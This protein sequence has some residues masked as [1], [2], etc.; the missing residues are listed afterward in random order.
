MDVEDV[1]VPLPTQICPGLY[2]GTERHACQRQLLLETL[3]YLQSGSSQP[4]P[5]RSIIN[6]TACSPNVFEESAGVTASTAESPD[7]EDEAALRFAYWRVAP[8]TLGAAGELTPA[9]RPAL[10]GATTFLKDA[11]QRKRPVLVH[12]DEGEGGSEAAATIVAAFLAEARA[13]HPAKAAEAVR[14]RRPAAQLSAAG[15]SRLEGLLGVEASTAAPEADGSLEGLS[16]PAAS[17]VVEGFLWL[18]NADAATPAGLRLLGVNAVLNVS[19]SLPMPDVPDVACHRMPASLSTGWPAARDFLRAAR[20]ENKR[21]LVFCETSARAAVVIMG[22]LMDAERT[23]TFTMAMRRV[24]GVRS[25]LKPDAAFSRQLME[26]KLDAEAKRPGVDHLDLA[27]QGGSLPEAPKLALEDDH[28]YME[29]LEQGVAQLG[30]FL[31]GVPA[32]MRREVLVRYRGNV[33]RAASEL[34]GWLEGDEVGGQ[35]GGGGAASSAGSSAGAVASSN[36][37]G[38]AGSGVAAPSAGDL[39]G[40]WRQAVGKQEG[41][42]SSSSAGVATSGSPGNPPN[43]AASLPCPEA[44]KLVDQFLGGEQQGTGAGSSSSSAAVVLQ[45][46]EQGLPPCILCDGT[47]SGPRQEHPGLGSVHKS[48][49]V[50]A[51]GMCD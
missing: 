29:R 45:H 9:S 22:H 2:L 24:R 44:V 8:S 37:A 15:V 47:R 39:F 11:L 49:L 50:E 35:R 21:V 46:E 27:V 1:T 4:A 12:G 43:L 5:I 31:P 51:T 14:D 30:D 25:G 16:P 36:S 32:D 20:H 18:G 10:K 41:G 23:L 28:A 7:D 48:C 34:M 17:E 42:A 13:L 26:V 19:Q 38:S 3:P 6:A 40:S 33:E